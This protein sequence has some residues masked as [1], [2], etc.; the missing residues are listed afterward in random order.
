MVYF[1]SYN[2]HKY[3]Y[4]NENPVDVIDNYNYIFKVN[5]LSQNKLEIIDVIYINTHYDYLN[6]DIIYNIFKEHSFVI[7]MNIHY[8]NNDV[9]FTHPYRGLYNPV[10]MFEMYKYSK[11]IYLESLDKIKET[12]IKKDKILSS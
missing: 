10:K 6:L 1:C 9:Y 12:M 4:V 7:G 8:E 2:N 3:S 5:T 11:Y